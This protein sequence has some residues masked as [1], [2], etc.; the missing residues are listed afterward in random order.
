MRADLSGEFRIRVALQRR[1]LAMD[2]VKIA[3]YKRVEAYHDRLF[4]LMMREVP[5]THESISMEQ[6]LRADT[7]AFV[8]MFDVCRRGISM[9]QNGEFP[10]EMALEHVFNDPIVSAT[11]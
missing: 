6:I 5:S 7:A 9:Q 2:L 11:L 4:H 1:S 10:I 3:T 8:S